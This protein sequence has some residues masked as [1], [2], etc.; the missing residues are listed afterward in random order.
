M[1]APPTPYDAEASADALSEAPREVAA[2]VYRIDVNHPRPRHTCAYLLV[3]DGAAAVIDCGG[4]TRG[5]AA[6]CNALAAL[7]IAAE[8]V[9]W[10]LV[11]HAHLD[12]AGA[13]GRLMQALPK[14]RFAAHP[15]ALKH[16]VD[17]HKALMPASLALFGK[18]FFEKFYGG[19]MPVP[20]ARAQALSD[21][22]RLPLGRGDLTA[23]FT[24]GHA[25]HHVSFF[26]AAASFIAAGDAYGV[27]YRQLDCAETGTGSG[28]GLL[29]PVMPPSQ[30]NPPAM[31]E[32]IRRLHGLGAAHMGLAHFDVL[33]TATAA[34]ADRYLNMQLEA[35][36]A[37]QPK[38]AALFAET[39]VRFY[40]RMK[41]YLLDWI[42]Q[43]AEA[44][45]ADRETAQRLHDNDA[46]LSALGFEYYLKKQAEKA[47]SA[48][49]DG[50]LLCH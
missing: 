26:D 27:S 2:G 41:A 42:T 35:L 11:T 21:G 20:A 23:V 30:F 15:S 18:P 22:E 49:R 16:L 43:R 24:P 5:A 47:I 48:R 13:A 37:W 17:P 38:A 25:W 34:N 29:V 31:E 19:L 32:S 45:G 50:G 40:P 28:M 33:D 6:V 14:A 12:H 7:G 39:P 36:A 4:G 3:K 44:Q 46:N 1:G 10:L 9:Q 8:A